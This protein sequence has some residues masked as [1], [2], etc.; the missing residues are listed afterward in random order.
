[1]ELPERPS[2][3]GEHRLAEVVLDQ[4]CQLL[5]G[6][7][8]EGGQYGLGFRFG[9]PKNRRNFVSAIRIPLDVDLCTCA[10]LS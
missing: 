1:M 9:P 8:G 3:H 5:H 7:G 2:G 6:R 10:G 4:S